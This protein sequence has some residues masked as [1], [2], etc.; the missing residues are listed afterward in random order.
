MALAGAE[1]AQMRQEQ[2]SLWLARPWIR[3]CLVACMPVVVF[4]SAPRRLLVLAAQG[5]QERDFKT[6]TYYMKARVR[7]VIKAK[8]WL[9]ISPSWRIGDP[10]VVRARWAG[11]GLWSSPKKRCTSSRHSLYKSRNTFEANPGPP[12]PTS[13]MRRRGAAAPADPL[14]M[15]MGFRGHPS[16]TR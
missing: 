8:K 1:A 14:R 11:L 2:A 9:D 7:V 3:A 12:T 4:V 13:I 10:A 5:G 15:E 6:C 16:R